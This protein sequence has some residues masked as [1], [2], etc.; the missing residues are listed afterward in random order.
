MDK[1]KNGWDNIDEL[2]GIPG[3]GL[4]SVD[5]FIKGRSV[6]IHQK[7]RGIF[8]RDF[9]IKSLSGIIIALNLFLYR[10]YES[11]M[12]FNAVILVLLLFAIIVQVRYYRM[13]KISADPSRSAKDNLTSLLTFIKR[14]FTVSA[15]VAASSY[16]FGFVPAMLLYFVLA[17]G[18]LEPPRPLAYFVYSFI[19]ITGMIASFTLDTRQARY[20]AR[21][22]QVCLSDLNDNALAMASENI[23]LKRRKD[24]LLVVLIQVL[25]LIGLIV[26]VA[27]LKGIMT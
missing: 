15:L 26:T 4:T 9:I 23:E 19:F 3:Y 12:I 1:I 6:S 11:I 7:I 8:M 16:F 13:F 20:H 18:Y 2:T 17:D 14:R 22:I 24:I 27:I 10:N 21:H 25:M 5:K